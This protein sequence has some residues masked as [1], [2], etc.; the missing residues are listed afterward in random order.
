MVPLRVLTLIF[1]GPEQP[2][3]LV[4]EP[5]EDQQPG[6]SRIVPVWIG[7][8]EAMQL[9]IALEH[10]KLPRPMTHDLFIDAITNLDACV[11]HVV[12]DRVEGQTF[13]A[14]LVLR[15][16]GRLIALD[17]RPTDALSLAIREDSPFMIEDQVL[18]QASFPYLFKDDKAKEVELQEFRTFLEGLSPEDFS[19]Q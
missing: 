14:K 17:A 18:Q 15:Q 7:A 4:L 3:V 6:K 8:N 5:I 10:A 1:T 9:G 13:F 12:I 16:G 11:D 2:A 19:Q